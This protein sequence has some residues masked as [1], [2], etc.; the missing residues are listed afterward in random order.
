MDNILTII[1]PT[2]NRRDNLN[3]LFKSLNDQTDRSFSWIIV[4]DGSSDDTQKLVNEFS[5][6]STFEIKYIRQKNQGKHIAI[7]V[8]ASLCKSELIFIVDSDDKVTKDAVEIIK[9]YWFVAKKHKCVGLSFLKKMKDNRTANKKFAQDIFI[10]NYNKQSIKKGM[11]LERVDIVTTKS[12]Q[13]HLFPQFREEKYMGEGI[14]WRRI[15]KNTKTLFANEEIYIAGY[16]EDGLTKKG[17]NLRI[18]N[19]LGAMLNENVLISSEYPL[20]YRIKHAGA[21]IAYGIFAK[22]KI[23]QILNESDYP[24]LILISLPF[25]LMVYLILKEK[26]GKDE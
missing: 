19:P 3:E 7:N 2:Y 8:G 13:E 10:T 11:P 21:Y 22:K 12:L 20:L 15:G 5:E 23:K 16:L 24:K 9:K 18:N 6:H 26:Y 17:W 14:L 4:D 1:T 25:G